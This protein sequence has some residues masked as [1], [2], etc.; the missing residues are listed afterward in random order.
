MLCC[1]LPPWHSQ[2]FYQGI[3]IFTFY[4]AKQSMQLVLVRNL[5]LNPHS[6]R[7]SK[8][9]YT[10]SNKES[11]NHVFTYNIWVPYLDFQVEHIISSINK[12]F[13][14]HQKLSLSIFLRFYGFW[15][16]RFIVIA[17]YGRMLFCFTFKQRP[18]DIN[19]I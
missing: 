9:V 8:Y 3:C 11:P 18:F 5:A 12:L 19:F 10:N 16:L 4:W 15:I 2:F 7:R 14:I 1:H 6:V 13:L 17:D